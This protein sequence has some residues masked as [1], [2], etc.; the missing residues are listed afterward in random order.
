MWEA[1]VVV[2]GKASLPGLLGAKL[3]CFLV[4]RTP[5]EV[6]G[7]TDF[8]RVE[9]EEVHEVALGPEADL[10]CLGQGEGGGASGPGGFF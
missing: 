10:H 8:Y 1:L 6:V 9:G 7:V 4:A 5:R 2:D 3:I